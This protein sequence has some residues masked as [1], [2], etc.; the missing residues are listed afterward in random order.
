MRNGTLKCIRF[1]TPERREKDTDL[2]WNEFKRFSK[3]KAGI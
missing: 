1:P 2:I 3:S